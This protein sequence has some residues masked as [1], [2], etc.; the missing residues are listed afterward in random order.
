MY[1][2][3]ILVSYLGYGFLIAVPCFLCRLFWDIVV[4]AFKRGS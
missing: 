2:V 4:S 1:N 3:D